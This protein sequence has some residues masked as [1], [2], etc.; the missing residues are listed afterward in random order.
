MKNLDKIE[1]LLGHDTVLELQSYDVEGL[2]TQVVNAESAM[3][4]AVD[5]LQANPQYQELK[6]GLKAITAGL[7]E[8]NKRQRAKI[9]YC[10]Y[11]LE[12]KGK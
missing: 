6:E 2:N 8:V 7:K 9:A 5:E 12:G 3:K 4:Q 11:L 1:K 10:L